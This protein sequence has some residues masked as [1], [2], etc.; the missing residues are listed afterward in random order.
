MVEST[1]ETT[2]N[3]SILEE[4]VEKTECMQIRGCDFVNKFLWI[5]YSYI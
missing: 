1:E 4:H 5:F 2:L 3:E